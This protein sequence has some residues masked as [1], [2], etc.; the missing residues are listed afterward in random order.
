MLGRGQ[1]SLPHQINFYFCRKLKVREK[2]EKK[3][4]VAHSVN[5]SQRYIAPCRALQ[6]EV[7]KHPVAANTA[8]HVTGTQQKQAFKRRWRI[9]GG[10]HW[11]TWYFLGLY[12]ERFLHLKWSFFCESHVWKCSRNEESEEKSIWISSLCNTENF[13]EISSFL[14][15]GNDGN[16]RIW[17]KSFQ[18]FGKSQNIRFNVSGFRNT[19]S[20]P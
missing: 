2:N 9:T 17:K 7:C 13:P 15:F 12:I 11:Y 5:F 18:G 10:K 3:N 4:K 14:P 8:K 6:S 1:L 19:E 20:W 16:R